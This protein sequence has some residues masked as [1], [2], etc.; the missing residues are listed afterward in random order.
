MAAEAKH[1][2]SSATPP[3]EHLK[4]E[5]SDLLAQKSQNPRD[6]AM[7]SG[8]LHVSPILPQRIVFEPSPALPAQDESHGKVHSQKPAVESSKK[9]ASSTKAAGVRKRLSQ[10]AKA[11]EYL[12][13]Q[14]E[15][16]QAQEMLCMFAAGIIVE[17]R[18]RQESICGIM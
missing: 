6:G 3:Q 2:S 17:R 5:P 7:T 16:L 8:N 13:Q 15:D 14:E 12:R 11:A 9:A 4:I 1:N 10:K 18:R